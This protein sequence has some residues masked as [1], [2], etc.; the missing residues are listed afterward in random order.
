MTHTSSVSEFVSVCVCFVSFVGWLDLIRCGAWPTHLLSRLFCLSASS[1]ALTIRRFQ[2][3]IL[4]LK[5][6]Y[7]TIVFFIALQLMHY[8][9]QED[10]RLHLQGFGLQ[11]YCSC[12]PHSGPTLNWQ[13]WPTIWEPLVTAWFSWHADKVER[14][15]IFNLCSEEVVHPQIDTFLCLH[16]EICILP[17][18]MA[19]N[20][21]TLQECDPALTSH[22]FSHPD[23]TLM[24]CLKGLTSQRS[25]FVSKFESGGHSLTKGR[26]RAA[27]AAMV[28]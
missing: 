17:P 10:F 27:R 2:S 20:R 21:K 12:F 4:I 14:S 5:Q 26:Y 24:K 6:T 11:V 15:W 8:E 16:K 9:S 19:D 1:H 7:K 25:L 22:F 23:I 3:T 28:L 18:C 13:N